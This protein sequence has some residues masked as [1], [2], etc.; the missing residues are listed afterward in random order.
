M[1]SL[2]LYV[3][4]CILCP[5]SMWTLNTTYGQNLFIRHFV[6]WQLCSNFSVQSIAIYICTFY[7]ADISEEEDNDV[8]AVW[9]LAWARDI[10]VPVNIHTS[11]VAHPACYSVKIRDTHQVEVAGVWGWPFTSVWCQAQNEWSHSLHSSIRLHGVSRQTSWFF[12]RSPHYNC[13]P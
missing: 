6:E 12:N 11:S 9:N 7:I 2:L 13:F 1:H 8:L 3:P 4:P 10:S 5:H